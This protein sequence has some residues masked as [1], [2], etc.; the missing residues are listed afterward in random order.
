M[1]TTHSDAYRKCARRHPISCR[2]EPEAAWKTVVLNRW[3][4][5]C[6]SCFDA[7]AEQAGV[8]YSFTELKGQSWSDS[9]TS[10]A[11]AVT[12]LAH[13]WRLS[14]PIFD[15]LGGEREFDPIE[16]VHE[17]VGGNAN[18]VL[19]NTKGLFNLGN[20]E[21]LAVVVRRSRDSADPSAVRGEDRKPNEE[22][23]ERRI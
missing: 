19:A 18:F 5:L 20:Q 13:G 1:V 3:R 8:R 21:C 6:P 9:E 7:E 4:I 23:S 17:H 10:Q 22:K 16:V 14:E 15:F 11:E 2:V 12:P